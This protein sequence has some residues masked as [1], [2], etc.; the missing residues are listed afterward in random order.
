M[1]EA[2]GPEPPLSEVRLLAVCLVTFAGF[3]RC[4]ELIKLKCCDI[5]FNAEGMGINV[6]S[7]KTDQYWE[8]ASLV[9][10][11]TGSVTCPMSMMERYFRVGKL[12]HT[13][14]GM[15]FRGIVQT[16]EGERLCKM[17]GISYSKNS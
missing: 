6:Q 11:R 5:T 2:A 16:K 12:E 8:G 10:A 3:L 1:V 17:G 14:H 4:N 13:S 7:S 9:I 15:L